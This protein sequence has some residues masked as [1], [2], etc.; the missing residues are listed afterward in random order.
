MPASI[1]A[2]MEMLLI[3]TLQA[4]EGLEKEWDTLLKKSIK[5]YPFLEY[6][7]QRTWWDFLGGGE[8]EPAESQLAIIVGYE[9]GEL[10]GIA[11]LFLSK[12]VD[13]PLALRFIGQIEVTDYLDFIAAPDDLEAFLSALLTYISNAELPSKRLDLANFQSDSPSL[14][15]LQNLCAE[16]GIDYDS[17][18]LQPAPSIFLPTTWEDYLQSLSKKQRHE[19]RRKER[20]VERD[21]NTQLTF[22]EAGEDIDA[23]MRDF[24]EM[25]RNEE[26]KAAFLTPLTEEFL[27]ELGKQARANER[28]KLAYLILNGE[29][30]AGYFNFISE[31]RLWVYNTGWN[32]E[33]AKAS[34]GWVLLVK[35]IQ[36]AIEN[37]LSEVDLMRGG[38]EY[39]YRFGALDREVVGVSIQLD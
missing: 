4:W 22:V 38:E 26:E 12:K 27:I 9:A 1:I 33:Y 21:Y 31:N 30:A 29:K 23:A 24:I 34:P 35:M 25:M 10:K 17:A 7:Y 11:P 13:N 5:P 36:W 39:K 15:V 6:W 18:V 3:D 16:Q 32:P 19:V 28:L 14:T 20:N 8:W 37:D 2:R